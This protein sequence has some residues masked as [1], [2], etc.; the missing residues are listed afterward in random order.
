M[1][2]LGRA[3]PQLEGLALR[4]DPD[5]KIVDDILPVAARLAQQR[6]DTS[7]LLRELLY[8][9][10]GDGNSIDGS[11]L[12]SLLKT[13]QQTSTS[14]T[15][16]LDAVL[17]DEATR[18]LACDEAVDALD[19][20]GRDLV[21]RAIGERGPPFLRAKAEALVAD[22]RVQDLERRLR[23]ASAQALELWTRLRGC[24]IW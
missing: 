22:R 13:A 23:T 5:F 10:A 24:A 2:L 20:L 14:A 19:S 17:E 3:V 9:V 15:S 6:S 4:A 18:A 11:K 1:V 7:S 21:W 16:S 12:R 8:G